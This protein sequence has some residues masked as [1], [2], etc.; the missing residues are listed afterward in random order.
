MLPR[1][2]S[3]SLIVDSA[4]RTSWNLGIACLA[5]RSNSFAMPVGDKTISATPSAIADF[6]MLWNCAVSSCAK[7][8]P[9]SV[10]MAFNPRVPSLAAPDNIIPIAVLWF[11]ASETKKLSTGMCRMG[12][13]F[14]WFKARV[15]LRKVISLSG[16]IMYIL[17][18]SIF[19]K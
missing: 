13:S 2:S 11:S 8:S 18:G 3:T 5:N 10:F 9:P 17:L 15:P 12:F 16:G 19:N 4:L 7:V 6:G 1:S 14:R